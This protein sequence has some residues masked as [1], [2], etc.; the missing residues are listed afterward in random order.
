MLFCS[1]M[2]GKF[3]HIFQLLVSNL[4][5][6]RSETN[7]NSFEVVKI[8]FMAKSNCL[9]FPFSQL[10]LINSQREHWASSRFLLPSLQPENLLP[11]TR[12]GSQ[13]THV[14]CFPSLR[15]HCPSLLDVH[16]YLFCLLFK[17]FPAGR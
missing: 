4:I 3:S 5:P 1:Y 12:L 6:L 8:C 16:C 9:V 14:F 13:S 2:S 11:A 17:L 15:Y 10:Y 7:L